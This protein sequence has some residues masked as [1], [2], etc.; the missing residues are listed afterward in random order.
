MA[1][2][3]NI[4]D[5]P[6]KP[7]MGRGKVIFT[8]TEPI[9][10][11]GNT[12]TRTANGQSVGN[13]ICASSS[14]GAAGNG[15]V[16][17]IQTLPQSFSGTGY[18][19]A[20]DRSIL[21]LGEGVT[22]PAEVNVYRSKEFTCGYTYDG[23][24]LSFT[25]LSSGSGTNKW[26]IYWDGGVSGDYTE[27]TPGGALP[28]GTVAGGTTVMI[29]GYRGANE[30]L[31]YMIPTVSAAGAAQSLYDD[32]LFDDADMFDWLGHENSALEEYCEE[33]YL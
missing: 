7:V 31:Y 27:Y 3:S 22:I 2:T 25:S 10:F 5:D 16:I 29:R 28:S 9:I 15:G 8:G 33:C 21:V 23:N 26:R 14:N 6:L 30:S 4:S 24:T 13:D 11:E 1:I 17:E 32:A 18:D 12:A 19:L 20:I